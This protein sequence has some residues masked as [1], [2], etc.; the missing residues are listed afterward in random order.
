MANVENWTQ[1]PKFKCNI[2]YDSNGRIV[3]SRALKIKGKI[4]YK[5]VK[6]DEYEAALVKSYNTFV[7]TFSTKY[8]V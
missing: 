1:E 7:S 3:R 2:K 6:V 4:K 8:K 5:M